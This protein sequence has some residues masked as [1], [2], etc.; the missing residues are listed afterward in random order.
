LTRNEGGNRDG[1][2]S[3]S[4]ELDFVRLTFA[5]DMHDRPYVSRLQTLGRKVFSQHDGFVFANHD[6]SGY[7]VTSLGATLAESMSHIVQTFRVPPVGDGSGPATTYSTPN[8]VF[9]EEL[10]LPDE[11]CCRSA[12]ARICQEAGWYPKSK[13]KRAFDLPTG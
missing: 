2:T 4:Y 8:G 13:K 3:Q 7:A 5:V 6:F 11:P 9:R 10:T 1:V 12:A